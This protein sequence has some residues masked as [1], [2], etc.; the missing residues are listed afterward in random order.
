MRKNNFYKQ[1]KLYLYVLL[2]FSSSQ[3]LRSAPANTSNIDSISEGFNIKKA[4]FLLPQA[5]TKGKY[6]SSI[7]LLN[8]FTPQDWTLD[9][10]KA[11]M[12]CYAGKYTLP[13]G[14]NLQGSLSTILVSNRI[15]L[16]P[17]WNYSIGNDHFG[18]GY[19]VAFNYGVLNQ[20]G[21]QST[22]TGWEQQPS[23]T[24]GHS[25]KTMAITFRG[26]LY[27]TTSLY[28][29]EGGNVIPFTNDYINGYSITGSLEQRLTKNKVMSIGLKWSYLRYHILAWP[30]FPVNSNR[31]DVPELQFG[32]NF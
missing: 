3:I 9:M 30:A 20:F 10:I 15:N 16:G 4:S 14:F 2:F 27:W 8:V 17:F 1:F 26:D 28:L 25:F 7:Y 11:P 22:L 18:V 32:L 12:I 13:K 24:Y 5:L 6:Y 19:Q 31:Y 21:Y 23:I 29:S